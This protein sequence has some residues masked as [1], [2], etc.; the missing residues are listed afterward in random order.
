C[1]ERNEVLGHV[2]HG[3]LFPLDRIFVRFV[4]GLV[5]VHARLVSRVLGGRVAIVAVTVGVVAG[6]V[7]AVGAVT[8]AGVAAAT[9]PMSVTPTISS[10]SHDSTLV[11]S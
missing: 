4:L 5:R 11:S 9:V 3:V 2:V 7:V 10:P 8:V 6:T 1:L